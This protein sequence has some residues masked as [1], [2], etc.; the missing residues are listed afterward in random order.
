MSPALSAQSLSTILDR[1]CQS[2]D[3][4]VLWINPSEP[5]LAA[6]INRGIEA[7]DS[8]PTT[9][10]LAE[11]WTLKQTLRKF[12]T[13]SKA[14]DLVAD[15]HLHLR[16]MDSP[17]K[18]AI[19]VDGTRAFSIVDG[20]DQFGLLTAESETFV[21]RL[22]DTYR[23]LFD[24]AETYTIQTPPI[25]QI[26]QT[27]DDRL[28]E[29]RRED[30]TTLVEAANGSDPEVDEVVLSLIVSAKNEDLLYDI[31]KWGEDIGLASKATFSRKKSLLEDGGF[32]DTEK[33]PIDV[34]RP[35][36]RL[37]FADSTL[38]DASPEHLV[39]RAANAI[40]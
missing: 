27:L 26:V 20:I 25:S 37:K 15:G 39:E 34:G 33:E 32:L 2:L 17:P 22:T 10:V 14:A 29:S 23:S 38:N 4:D 5:M 13:A 18:S 35:R 9:Y 11:E 40:A 6:I 24:E 16:Y 3:G 36:L 30:F 12:T 19:A 31:S 28:G 8:F 1:L 7:D 21:Q